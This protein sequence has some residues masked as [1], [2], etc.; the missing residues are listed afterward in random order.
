[1]NFAVPSA[2]GYWVKKVIFINI[3]SDPPTLKSDNQ[4]F[5]N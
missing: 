3:G 4:F 5:G 1:M 2:I